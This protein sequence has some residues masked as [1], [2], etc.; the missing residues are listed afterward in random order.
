MKIEIKTHFN[1]IGFTDAAVSAFKQGVADACD[2]TAPDSE[3][4]CP[5]RT[6]ALKSTIRIMSQYVRADYISQKIRAGKT[7]APYANIV[8]IRQ[9]FLRPALD[10]NENAAVDNF[11]G[12]LEVEA[13]RSIRWR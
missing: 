7:A 4:R 13:S 12:L 5:V 8:E 6:G 9:P 10:E 11:E 3:D 2:M 1:K